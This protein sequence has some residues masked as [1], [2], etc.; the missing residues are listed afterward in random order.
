MKNVNKNM[1]SVIIP[2]YNVEKFLEK[3]I[4]SVIEQSFSNLEI[5]LIDDGSTDGSPKICDEYANRDKRIRVI[6]QSNRGLSAARNSGLDIA[7]G[8]NI[9][10]LDSDDTLQ[11]N[12]IDEL[13]RVK[14]KHKAMISA[15]SLNYVFQDGTQKRRGELLKADIFFPFEK[16]IE[17]MNR[18]C[19]FDMCANAKM[20]SKELFSDIRFPVGKLSEDLFVM[21]K[22]IKRAKGVAYT[23]FTA[24]NYL[25]RDGGITKSKRI[26]EDIIEASEEQIKILK[27]ENKD[28]VAIAHAAYASAALTVYDLY[29]KNGV[30]CPKNKRKFFKEI[31]VDNWGFIKSAKTVKGSKRIQFVLFRYFGILYDAVFKGYRKIKRV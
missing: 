1:V 31:V 16:A 24:Y 25:Q 13:Y 7:S 15:C 19:Y 28:I 22:L 14:N 21:P 12:L 27:D 5:I 26:N 10:F 17:E 20:Y 8:E 30:E 3:C 18:Y 23:P 9:V 2:V 4:D 6:H 29:I 11:S